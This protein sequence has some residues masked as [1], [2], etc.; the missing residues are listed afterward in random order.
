MLLFQMTSLI[1]TAGEGKG[2]WA[3]LYKLI[4]QEPWDA[5]YIVTT[6]YGMEHFLPAKEIHC[7]CIDSVLPIHQIKNTIKKGISG[8]I[9]DLETALCLISGNGKD[10]MAVLG[11]IAEL[12]LGYRLVSIENERMVEVQANFMCDGSGTL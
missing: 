1:A 5:I 6:P 11:A 2:T 8:K 12:G 10:H 4:A 9:N 7:I 3:L